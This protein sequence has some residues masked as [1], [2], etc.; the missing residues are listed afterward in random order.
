V[1]YSQ[2]TALLSQYFPV[3]HATVYYGLN[4]LEYIQRWC[5]YWEV[6]DLQLH[7]VTIKH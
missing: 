3:H 6:P 2:N 4:Y 1:T 5:T 7:I